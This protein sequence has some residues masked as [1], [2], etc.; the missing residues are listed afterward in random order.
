MQRF[1][2]SDRPRRLRRWLG[3]GAAFVGTLFLGGQAASAS[4]VGS[5]TSS[6]AE[7][8]GLYIETI[9]VE[10]TRAASPAII[11]SESLLVEG[12]VYDELDLLDAINRIRRLPFVLKAELSLRKGSERGKL[13]LVIE[14][15]EVRRFF[16]GVDAQTTAFG[17]GLGFERRFLDDVNHQIFALAGARWFLGSYGVFF[18]SVSTGTSLQLGYTRY[19]LFDRGAFLN[20]GYEVIGCCETDVLPLG[21]DP[22]FSSWSNEGNSERG[23]VTLGMPLDSIRSLRLEVSH[24]DGEEGFRREV[25]EPLTSRLL[26]DFEGRQES[27]LELAWTYDTT[28]DP[29]FPSRGLAMTA[30]IEAQRLEASFVE[31][32]ILIRGFLD[33]ILL[34]PTSVEMRSHLYRAVFSGTR[35]WSMGRRNVLSLGWRVGAGR[36]TLDN[37]P[38]EQGVIESLDLDVWE[39]AVSL[40]HSLAVWGSPRQDR[41]RELFWENTFEAGLEGTSPASGGLADSLERIGLTTS[42][43]YRTRWGIFRFGFS[44]VDVGR[45]T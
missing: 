6:L 30:A 32:G 9:E 1:S 22:T 4:P 42:L 36:S 34:I 10:G 5:A 20:V 44:Y 25:I 31:P 28:D 14:V 23:T 21:L 45:A 11:R 12:K 35:H 33:P 39:A 17:D 24:L 41:H 26:F 27:R 40:R 3:C 18:A 8:P 19:Q 29:S 13:T 16:F 37:V 15:E 43:S 7:W 2:R 38:T